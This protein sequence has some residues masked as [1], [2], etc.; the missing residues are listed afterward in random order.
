MLCIPKAINA[1]H[2]TAAF[3]A[4]LQQLRAVHFAVSGDYGP[5]ATADELATT[6]GGPGT[7]PSTEAAAVAAAAATTWRP[8]QPPTPAAGTLCT[9]DSVQPQAAAPAAPPQQAA[10]GPAEQ[11][12]P[13]VGSPTRNGASRR[14]P[15]HQGYPSPAID[16]RV[17]ESRSRSRDGDSDAENECG[18]CS[19][20]SD[21]EDVYG[22]RRRR[23]PLEWQKDAA[24]G[25]KDLRSFFAGQS[26]AGPAADHVQDEAAGEGAACG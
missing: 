1:G 19:S 14:A 20:N 5:T 7:A 21:T 13:A 6:P 26:G 17:P 18:S 12:A 22:P 2:F 4:V 11:P 8:V 16:R 3:D 10:C 9:T 15:C 23:G 25:S 24:V